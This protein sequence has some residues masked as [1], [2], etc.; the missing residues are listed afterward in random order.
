MSIIIFIIVLAVLVF[1]HELGHFLAAKI[2]GIRVD[3]FALGFPPTLFSKT[4]GETKYSLNL[5]PF[6]GFVKIHGENPDEDST[7]GPDASR[8]FSSKNRFIQAFVLL[9]G[10][11]FNI[12]FAWIILSIGFTVGMPPLTQ[13]ASH[14]QY[15]QTS[16]IEIRSLKAGSPAEMGGFMVGD[17]IKKI[18]LQTQVLDNPESSEPIQQL[19]QGSEG[20]ELTFTMSRKGVSKELRVTP[21]ENVVAGKY[22]IG[23]EMGQD[24]LVKAPFPISFVEGAKETV[25]ITKMVAAGLSDFVI[26]IFKGKPDYSQVSGPVGIVRVIGSALKLG[27]SYVVGLTAIISINLAIINLVPFP[28]LDGGRLLFVIIE[29]IIRRPLPQKFVN[30][31]NIGGFLILILLMVVITGKDLWDVYKTSVFHLGK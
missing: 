6:G 30:Y 29:G 9:G 27:F 8:S 23:I 19:I 25:N 1:V 21:S 14:S 5:V 10:I 26:N 11:I 24:A 28:A 17:V 13:E 16:G 31:V 20:K 22:A 12:L 3:E 7:T 15:I 2:S 18:T 4:V